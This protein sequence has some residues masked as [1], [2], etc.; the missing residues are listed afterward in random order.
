MPDHAVTLPCPVPVAVPRL[1]LMHRQ[2]MMF[3]VPLSTRAPVIQPG[4]R[5]CSMH[6][7]G[8][9]WVVGYAAAVDRCLDPFSTA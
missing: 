5:H 4:L 8:S 3:T 2:W 6:I 7:G 1:E 9:G